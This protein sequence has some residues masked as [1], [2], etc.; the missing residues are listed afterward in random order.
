MFCYFNCYASIYILVFNIFVTFTILIL[1]FYFYHCN[2]RLFYHKF[3]FYLFPFL[4]QNNT[5]LDL[6]ILYVHFNFTPSYPPGY[7]GS[8]MVENVGRVRLS[9]VEQ[10]RLDCLGYVGL[11]RLHW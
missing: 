6:S 10:L 9:K 11:G 2:I 5:V 3:V 7:L 4:F 1:S 8:V